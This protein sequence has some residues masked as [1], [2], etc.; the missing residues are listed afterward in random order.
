MKLAPL[1]ALVSLV[2]LQPAKPV[3]TAI[4]RLATC[5][6]SWR[7]W[8]DDPAQSKKVG[9]LF[10]STFS[11][12]GKDG[13]FAPKENVQVVGLPVTLVYPES[14]GMGVGFS[15]VLDATFDTAREHVEKALGKKLTECDVSDGMRTCGLELE[16]EKTVTLMAGEH[17]E[18]RRTLLG[19]YYF[20]AK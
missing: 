3:E 19:C 6:D 10:T 2:A 15:V 12:A 9:E 13:S 4:E 11:Q 16:K 17:D 8:K 5:Q 18:K 7:D 20:Y 1:L 14:V